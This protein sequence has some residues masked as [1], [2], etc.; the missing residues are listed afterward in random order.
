[1]RN[2]K[3]SDKA[4]DR[5]PKPS[6]SCC[7]Y[8]IA[9]PVRMFTK[10]DLLNFVKKQEIAVWWNSVERNAKLSSAFRSLVLSLMERKG[11]GA[12]KLKENLSKHRIP[13]LLCCRNLIRLALVEYAYYCE[14]SGEKMLSPKRISELLGCS[15]V[16]ANM[17]NTE[18]GARLRRSRLVSSAYSRFSDFQQV[19]LRYRTLPVRDCCICATMGAGKS[20]F[21]NALLGSDVLPVRNEATTAKVTSVY[22]RDGEIGLVGYCQGRNGGLKDF[23]EALTLKHL[24]VWNS[25]KDVARVFLRGDFNGIGNKGMI[26]AMHDTPG[27]NNS[28]DSTHHDIT[29]NFLL[30]HKIDL[31]LFILNAEH[32]GTTDEKALLTD[33]QKITRGSPTPILFVLNKADSIDPGKESLGQM[34]DKYKKYLVSLGFVR[35]EI[36]PVA[37]KAARLIKIAICG[38]ADVMTD[39]EKDGFPIVV[40]WMNKHPIAGCQCRKGP[41]NGG[42]R[43]KVDDESY[44]AS[45]LDGALRHTGFSDLENRIEELLLKKKGH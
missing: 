39:S 14:V 29:I 36:M 10:I 28:S 15:M 37:S 34:V 25:D 23:R 8:R 35:P 5:L 17:S 38:N 20:T 22:D 45:E 44:L 6:A 40:N 18:R 4:T 3:Q 11:V 16:E 7:F 2:S 12:D 27:T 21:T 33:V 19:D 30:N 32:L 1:M 41:S 24:N 43:I 26:A 13:W 9:D 42:R 31:L